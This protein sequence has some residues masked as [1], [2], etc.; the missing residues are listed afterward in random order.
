MYSSKKEAKG[1][2]TVIIIIVLILM[3]MHSC[4]RVTTEATY[5]VVVTEKTVKRIDDEDRYLVYTELLDTGDVRVFQI[6]DSM[7]RMRFDSADMYA[8]IKV[9]TSYQFEV[10][11]MREE[12]LSN[13]ENIIAIKE[14]K[15]NE[16]TT[17][18]QTE[19]VT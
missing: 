3:F 18:S 17:E 11:G 10:Y 13:Y 4:E 8:K 6:T 16:T 7:S 9:G 1:G 15:S 19:T 12:L 2:S 14:I 5:N